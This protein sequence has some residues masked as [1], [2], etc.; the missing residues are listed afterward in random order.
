MVNDAADYLVRLRHR[1]HAHVR[2]ECLCQAQ[3][4]SI[5]EKRQCT[6]TSRFLCLNYVNHSL[7]CSKTMHSTGAE[8]E[9]VSV[10]LFTIGNITMTL[11][12]SYDLLC[13]M[14]GNASLHWHSVMD[15]CSIIIQISIV[16]ISSTLRFK[17]PFTL[18]FV[19]TTTSLHSH[20][21]HLRRARLHTFIVA[22]S[23]DRIS[24][25]LAI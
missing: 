10:L 2:Q 20:R 22:L 24:L 7:V 11:L 9:R 16:R 15:A 19:V 5:D 25:Q 6:G 17:Q 4:L 18:Y 8:D 3:C 14:I 13:T 1:R 23:M 12:L 21:S